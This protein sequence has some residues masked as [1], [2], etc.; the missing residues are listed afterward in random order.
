VSV[1]SPILSAGFSRIL[2]ARA[3]GRLRAASGL[4]VAVA[5]TLGF[6][7]SLAACSRA[8]RPP[9]GPAAAVPAPERDPDLATLAAW[10]TGSFSSARQA[11]ADT[12]FADIRLRTVRI[13]PGR[14]DLFWLYV[15]QSVAGDET[16]P[17][18]Q[19]V[20]RLTKTGENLFE[21]AVFQLPDPA[22]FVGAWRDPAILSALT[23]DSLE[24]RTGCDIRLRRMG[25]RFVGATDGQG[26][27]SRLRGASYATSEVVITENAMT[28]WDRGFDAGGRQVWG[29]ETG[30]YV[31]D[32]ISDD[33]SAE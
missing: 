27:E 15:E 17:Y 14:E 1:L 23:P 30:G 31:F 29:S 20:Y 11:A 13:W 32:K 2:S 3:I 28:T 5:L 33:A 4:A 6:T 19:R 18:R 21:S 10:M 16:R 7:L 24:A 9:A 12:S 8:T 26:C 25:D 22:R